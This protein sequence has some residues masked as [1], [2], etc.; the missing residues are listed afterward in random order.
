MAAAQAAPF[1]GELSVLTDGDR[2]GEEGGYVE[3]E[4]F[5]RPSR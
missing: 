5:G 2:S 1:I 4:V 3:V